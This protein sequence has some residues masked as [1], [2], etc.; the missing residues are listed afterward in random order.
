MQPGAITAVHVHVA[1]EGLGGAELP[2]AECARVGARRPRAAQHVARRVL[3]ERPDFPR[4]VL[5]VW[6]CLIVAAIV[7]VPHREM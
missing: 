7:V 1:A 6:R 5:V 3:L 2:P 4:I